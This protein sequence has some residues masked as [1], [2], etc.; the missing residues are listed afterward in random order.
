MSNDR[1]VRIRPKDAARGLFYGGS[2][3]PSMLA[4]SSLPWLSDSISELPWLKPSYEELPWLNNKFVATDS[5]S[6]PMSQIPGAI[7]GLSINSIDD[8]LNNLS[9]S[10]TQSVSQTSSTT[11]ILNPLAQTNGMVWMYTPTVTVSGAV[12]YNSYDPVHSNQEFAA[13]TRTRATSIQIDGEF[14]AQNMDESAYLLACIHFLR[15][16]TKMNFGQSTNAGTPPPILLLSGY[17]EY[18]FNDLPV[19][20]E[21]YNITLPQ[22][23]DYVRINQFTDTYVPS[24]MNISV[25]LKVQNTPAKNRTF[26]ID[27]FRSGKLMKKKGWI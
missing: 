15:T 19:I 13:Y 17:G 21:Q 25:S 24:R 3:S 8:I 16:V 18:M 11:N 27:E 20:L 26:N 4:D 12:D 7:D 22:D 9:S 6:T 5:P 1:R 10:V 23:V 14:S 2:N